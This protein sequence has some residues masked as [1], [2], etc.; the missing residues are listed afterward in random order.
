MVDGNG[1]ATARFYVTLFA[2]SKMISPATPTPDGSKAPIMVVFEINGQRVMAINGGPAHALSPAFSLFVDCD[3]QEEV[4][5]YWNAFL[6]DGGTESKCGWLTDRYG[7]SWQI[8]PKQLMELMGDSDPE[9]SGRVVNA[10]LK[11]RKIIVADLQAA[12]AG[13]G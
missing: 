12:H 4:D 7:V 6:A 1:E 3:G 8:V 10:M 9:K 5:Q 2:N 13:Q 11:M